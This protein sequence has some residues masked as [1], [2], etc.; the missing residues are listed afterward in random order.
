[1]ILPTPAVTI[2]FF[3]VLSA[4]VT[5]VGCATGQTRHATSTVEYLYPNTKDPI[6]TPGIPVLTLPMR[7]GIAFV[8]G[9]GGGNYGR[10]MMVARN[11]SFVLTE[12]KKMDL[13]QEVANH[14]KKYPYVKDIELIPS[15]YLT[16]RGSFA[17]L[18]QI[19]TMYGIDVIALLS[20]DQVQFTD[21]GLLSLTYWTLVGAYIIPG[22][23][24]DTHTML[25]AVVYDI[26]SRKMLFRAPGT[27]H[28]KGK[29]TLVNLSERLREDSEK[30]FDEASKNMIVNLDQQLAVFKEKVKER[31]TEYKVVHSPGYSGGGS[32]DPIW[33][34]ALLALGGIFL[35]K[36]RS[37]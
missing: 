22:E 18:D 35:W 19:R 16:P 8:P 36:R 13:M 27:N 2:S 5:L 1:M 29:A 10:G 4:V 28:I 20:Y 24:N 31:P 21:E 11:Q 32:F 7:V 26:K 3:A 25:D 23:K 6:V 30:G 37:A 34:V 9:S 12:K 17:N 15:A 33:L 14:F